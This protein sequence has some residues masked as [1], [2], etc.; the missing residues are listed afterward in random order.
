MIKKNSVSDSFGE[1]VQCELD[2]YYSK[3]RFGSAG[4]NFSYPD[5]LS[6]NDSTC[7]NV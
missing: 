7:Y 3:D 2:E 6:L 1:C 5:P 4:E